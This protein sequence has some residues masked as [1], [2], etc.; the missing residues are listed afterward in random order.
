M[1]IIQ[2]WIKMADIASTK[3]FD[4]VQMNFRLVFF[5][6]FC[7]YVVRVIVLGVHQCTLLW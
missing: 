4:R 3:S 6:T 5:S 1:G 7:D 2:V